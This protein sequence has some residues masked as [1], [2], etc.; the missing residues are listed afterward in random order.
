[1]TTEHAVSTKGGEKPVAD[2][3]VAAPAQSDNAPAASAA[4]PAQKSESSA[5]AA[6]PAQGKESPLPA[7]AVA[8]A[9]GSESPSAATAAA[10][11]NVS[12]PPAAA[13]AAAAAPAQGSGSPP[14]LAPAA[15]GLEVDDDSDSELDS[16]LGSDD[17]TSLN[18]SIS[19]S[20]Y[21]FRQENGRTYHRYKEGQYAFANDETE[22]ERLEVE[23]ELFQYLVG[24]RLHVAPLEAEKVRNVLD[25]GT[26]TGIW[27]V[28]MGEE[29]PGA[30]VVGTELSPIQSGFGLPNVSFIVDDANDD[31][32]FE[33]RFDYIR[34]SQ[35]HSAAEEKRL[36]AQAKEHLVPGGWLEMVQI[37][38]PLTSD[39][40]TLVEGSPLDQ[41]GKLVLEATKR[42][43]QPVDNAKHYA[44]WMRDAGFVDVHEDVFKVPV[45]PWVKNKAVALLSMENALSAAPMAAMATFTRVLG[46]SREEVE[47][48]LVGVRKQIKD[49]SVHSY[50]PLYVVYGRKP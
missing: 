4:E 46:W 50:C 40:G 45:G 24:G 16:A 48:F 43:G 38:Y 25:I 37:T 18:T 17:E 6:A 5:A 3:P 28:A 31:W 36:F 13:P 44:Q 41:Y 29:Y 27:A 34:A 35:L 8:A 1:M 7:A 49:R 12:P 20:I 11:G 33:Q 15:A 19:S 30:E 10:Q 26:G 22:Q 14:S 39:D 47:I 21:N 9:Q 42:T 23:H 32:I 2:V